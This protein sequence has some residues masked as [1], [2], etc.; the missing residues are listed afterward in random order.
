MSFA[1]VCGVRSPLQCWRLLGLLLVVVCSTAICAIA[2]PARANAQR[3]RSSKVKS[4]SA[5]V[6]AKASAKTSAKRAKN[7]GS[8]AT[9]LV[10][11]KAKKSSIWKSRRTLS[12]TDS[13][14]KNHAS[15]HSELSPKDYLKLGQANI[16][17]GKTLKGGGRHADARYHIRKLPTGEF[18]MTITDK[19][20]KILSIDTWKTPGVPLTREVIERGLK[21][22]GVTPP[23]KFF[24][25]LK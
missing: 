5:K 22:S 20:G 14:L 6:S 18:S 21:A 13:G 7:P 16:R 3:V 4:H 24:S 8:R 19:R 9:G 23:K 12:S 1:L 10:G 2:L 11:T 17:H 15:R 25:K